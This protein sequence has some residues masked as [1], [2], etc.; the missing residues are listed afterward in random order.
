[1]WT[2][3]FGRGIVASTDNFGTSGKL[4]DNQP[5]LDYLA[6]RLRGDCAWSLKK[7]IREIVVSHAYQLGSG[8]DEKNFQADP[9]N[10]LCWRVSRRRLDAE[11]IRD[12]MLAV[13][14]QLN[15]ERPV[16]SVVAYY[17]DGLIGGPRLR[18]MNEEYV[19]D[20]ASLRRSVY[21]PT[22]RDVLP[23]ALALFDFA[24][25][26]LVTGARD[27]TNVPAQALFLLN[28]EF[29]ATQAEKF[30]EKL[31]AAYP[32][33]GANA[34]AGDRLKERL[35]WAYGLCFS[36][37]PTEAELKAAQDYFFKYPAKETRGDPVK[38]AWTGLCRALFASA[39]F[40]CLN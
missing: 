35:Q 24:D 19:I 27:T 28:S 37:W 30:A 34:G 11:C 3:L 5:L 15:L 40:R 39:E 26:S 12:A 21:L 4:P 9:D 38:T 6:L 17:G 22:P 18:G 36:R 29:A 16:G 33:S 7:L 2:W 31:L 13:S 10:A 23:E 32:S 8:H 1:V 14:S 25:S 20:P